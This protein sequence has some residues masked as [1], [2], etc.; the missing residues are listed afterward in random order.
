MTQTN[1]VDL[2]ALLAHSNFALQATRKAGLDFGAALDQAQQA[3]RFQ[4]ADKP[5]E[6][7]RQDNTPSDRTN[8]QPS[9]TQQ[10]QRPDHAQAKQADQNAP[11]KSEDSQAPAKPV[12]NSDPQNAK[13]ETASKTDSADKSTTA[14]ATGKTDPNAKADP[15]AQADAKANQADKSDPN[16]QTA[17]QSTTPDAQAQAMLAVLVATPLVST[18]TVQQQ[19][20]Q[21]EGTAQAITANSNQPAQTAGQ[22][23]QTAQAQSAQAQATQAQLQALQQLGQTGTPGTPANAQA[24]A[25]AQQSQVQAQNAQNVPAFVT[26]ASKDLGN[27]KIETATAVKPGEAVQ[28]THIEAKGP[29]ANLITQLLDNLKQQETNGSTTTAQTLDGAQP[30]G[31]SA[32]LAALM[33]A[34]DQ[35]PQQQSQDQGSDPQSANQ[36]VQVL[37]PDNGPKSI[38]AKLAVAQ[39][40]E[41]PRGDDVM[42]QI[43]KQM[44][45]LKAGQQ[46]TLKLQLSPEHLGK[47]EIKVMS[48]NGVVS[49]SITSDNQQVK[50]LI[51]NQVATLQQALSDLGIKVDRVD[52]ALNSAQLGNNGFGAAAQQQGQMFQQQQQANPGL[53]QAAGYRQWLADDPSDEVFAQ[54]APTD[55]LS[56]VNYVA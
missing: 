10:A 55:D 31:M 7:V 32:P 34:A 30:T 27:I 9:D 6:P 3:S 52:V 39:Q 48:Q 49:A 24:Q 29:A 2:G 35:Q 33:Q 56:A 20:I 12:K 51:D 18:Q 50:G 36:L 46:N 1:A 42:T 17:S 45:A 19:A 4:L 54:L 15:N 37:G 16:A 13:P 41:G 23:A 43:V 38:D 21:T 53:F 11:A 26:Q 14:N 44:D 25:Q 5:Q 22:Q 28:V 47:I 40:V 8:D